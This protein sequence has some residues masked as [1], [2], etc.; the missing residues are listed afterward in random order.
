ME[1]LQVSV[2]SSGLWCSV[3]DLLAYRADS[4]AG[5]HFKALMFIPSELP[6]DFWQKSDKGI[7]NV[8]MMVKR[9]S[10]PSSNA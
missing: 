3:A 4:G 1:P 7:K 8:R 6:Q 2:A 10:L 5:I 9:V